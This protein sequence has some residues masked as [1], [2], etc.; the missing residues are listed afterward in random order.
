[1]GEKQGAIIMNMTSTNPR[2]LLTT[3]YQRFPG[4]YSELLS[5]VVLGIPRISMKRTISPGLRFIKQNVPEVEMLE[6]PL[7]HEYVAK[8]KEGWDIVGFSFYQNEISEIERMAE[9]ARRHGVKETWAGNYGVLDEKIPSIVDKVI[10]GSAEDKVAQLFGYRVADDEIEHPVI[11]FHGS[12][13]PGNI[14]HFT[15]GVLHTQRGC[16]FKCTFCQ[17]PAFEN[18]RF[19]INFGSIERVLKYYRSKHIN[20]IFI[21]DEL[22]GVNP[23]FTERLIQSL[24]RY[25]FY[26]WAMSRVSL[27]IRNLDLW[28]EHGLRLPTIGVETMTQSSLDDVHKKQKVEEVLEF[29]R[30]TR[31]KRDLFRTAY[32]MIGYRNMDAEEAMQDAILLKQI[33]FD[34]H[35]ANI[36]TPFPKTKLWDE[37][38]SQYGIFDHTYRHYDAKH[39]VWRHPYISP[40][41]MQSLY[42]SIATFLNK[43]FPSYIKTFKRFFIGGL[44]NKGPGFIWSGLIREPINSMFINDKKQVF[45]PKIKNSKSQHESEAGGTESPQVEKEK[46][47]RQPPH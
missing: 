19:A 7:W 37:L 15:A 14:R 34:I 6:Y 11:T 40:N 2:V 35:S 10:I 47:L 36:L 13:V 21:I 5:E 30:L 16:P 17:T 20:Y 33:G 23:Q 29:S 3:T 45:F 28:Y 32:Y 31:E 42:K 8:L 39:L 4:D 22:F 46:R 18:R 1:L 26:W 24:A 41:Q 44:Q 9:E 12:L 38:D 27:F 43:P 25:G